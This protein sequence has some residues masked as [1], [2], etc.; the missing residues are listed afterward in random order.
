MEGGYRGIVGGN[1]GWTK[2][3]MNE[4]E[5]GINLNPNAERFCEE[6]NKD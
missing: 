4:W 5:I 6:G 2:V 3:R 1:E